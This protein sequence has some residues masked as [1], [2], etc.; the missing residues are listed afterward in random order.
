MNVSLVSFLRFSISSLSL[1]FSKNH[2]RIPFSN[3][4]RPFASPISQLLLCSQLL[5]FRSVTRIILYPFLHDSHLY[6]Y[7]PTHLLSHVLCHLQSIHRRKKM[8][9]DCGFEVWNSPCRQEKIQFQ[10]KEQEDFTYRFNYLRESVERNTLNRQLL[11]QYI[12]LKKTSVIRML[13][14]YGTRKWWFT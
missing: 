14:C 12:N 5:F 11:M 8:F 2:D 13:T 10:E 9:A 4:S 1:P 7:A 3:D 6:S